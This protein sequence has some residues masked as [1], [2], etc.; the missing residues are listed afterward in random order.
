VRRR[1]C[2]DSF[3]RR[4]VGSIEGTLRGASG[5]HG[6]RLILG[7]IVRVEISLEVPDTQSK[8]LEFVDGKGSEGIEFGIELG[9]DGSDGL[10]TLGLPDGDAI[11]SSKGIWVGISINLLASVIRGGLAGLGRRNG[12]KWTVVV[13]VVVVVVRRVAG[14]KWSVEC[15][16]DAGD[17]GCWEAMWMPGIARRLE[18]R[19]RPR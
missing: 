13:V 2:A 8:A 9:R 6:R 17:A 10:P 1:Q 3:A 14:A 7:M 16:G 4:T 18:T 15:L 11:V 19:E 5:W 12:V